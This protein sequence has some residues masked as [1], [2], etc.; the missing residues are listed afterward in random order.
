L[1]P[2]QNR[3]GEVK[4]DHNSCDD[5]LKKKQILSRLFM[6]LINLN[7]PWYT[8]AGDKNESLWRYLPSWHNGRMCE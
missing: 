1:I 8:D 5:N 3:S 6:D 2:Q 4:K 7:K